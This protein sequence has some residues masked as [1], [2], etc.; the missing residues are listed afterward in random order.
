MIKYNY[1]ERKKMK[2]FLVNESGDIVKFFSTAEEANDWMDA[3]AE[4]ETYEL[5]SEVIPELS[6]MS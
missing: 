3:Y 6:K 5:W 2:W 1:N 4:D